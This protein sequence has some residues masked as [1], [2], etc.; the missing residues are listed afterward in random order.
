MKPILCVDESAVARREQDLGVDPRMPLAEPLRQHDVLVSTLLRARHVGQ[1][2]RDLGIVVTKTISR[3][4]E[5]Q[6]AASAVSRAL[7]TSGGVSFG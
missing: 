6:R 3:L 2:Q 7:M 5:R 1:R 4:F